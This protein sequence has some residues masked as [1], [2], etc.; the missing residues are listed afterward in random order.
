MTNNGNQT[1]AK[2]FTHST[3]F[4]SSLGFSIYQFEY[5]LAKMIIVSV[6]LL[7]TDHSYLLRTSHVLHANIFCLL[8]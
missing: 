2:S 3:A 5:N 7:H 1:G 4:G 6:A 8:F